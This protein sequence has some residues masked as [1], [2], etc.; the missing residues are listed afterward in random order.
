MPSIQGAFGDHLFFADLQPNWR[1]KLKSTLNRSLGATWVII[2]FC[3]ISEPVTSRVFAAGGADK[4]VQVV[5][6]IDYAQDAQ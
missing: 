6:D 4:R 1:L 2:R 3:E 5:A